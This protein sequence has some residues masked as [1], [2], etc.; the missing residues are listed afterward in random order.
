MVLLAVALVSQFV[1]GR[2]TFRAETKQET[3]AEEVWSVLTEASGY[4]AWN[5]LPVPIRGE[6]RQ[7]VRIEYRMTQPNGT[8]STIKS[9]TG[10]VIVP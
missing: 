3:T 6:T 4:G 7:G 10:M 5:P 8:R 2:K 9:R 1:L